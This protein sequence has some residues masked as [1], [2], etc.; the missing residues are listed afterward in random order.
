M[1]IGMDLFDVQLVEAY[2]MDDAINGFSSH[3]SLDELTFSQTRLRRGQVWG[4]S[5]F[6]VL[7]AWYVLPKIQ[8]Q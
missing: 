3:G 7:P 8:C 5:I 4:L 2:L 1:C 6:K